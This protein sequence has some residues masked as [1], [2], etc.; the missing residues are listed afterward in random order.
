MN[1]FGR[2]FRIQL[3]G[4]SHGPYVGVTIDGCPAGLALTVDDFEDD[5][6]RRR[7]GAAGTTDRQEPD[8]PEI[9]SGWHNGRT[10][11][12]PLTLLFANKDVDSTDYEPF[13]AIPRP[14]HADFAAS[15]KWQ[16]YNDLRGGGYLSGRLTVAL[17]AAGVIAKKLIAPI[18]VYANLIMAG[19]S[20]DI[21]EA[22]E[23]AVKE[24]DSIG[25]LI[26][27]CAQ[28]V[29]CGWG[30]PFF[31][32][33]ESLLSHLLFSIPGVKGV[34]FGAGF[35]AAEMRGSEYNDAIISPAGKTKENN[36][37]GIIGGITNGNDLLLTVALRPAASIKKIQKAFDLTTEKELGFQLSGRHDSCFALRAP[38]IVEA[39][40]AIVLADLSFLPIIAPSQ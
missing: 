12:A 15:K 3:F 39:A 24:G 13:R 21:Q 6:S 5:L 14:G 4:E 9:I 32:S 35:D 10:T 18:N 2:I 17:V 40:V 11:G 25:G 30:E 19:G 20:Y 34:E 16:G 36:A 37:G 23:A 33:V 1:S 38:V 26:E 28:G 22:V 7:S 29:P 31:D 8:V 27:C